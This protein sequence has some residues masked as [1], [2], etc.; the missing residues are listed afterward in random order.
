[1]TIGDCLIYSNSFY[2]NLADFIFLKYKVIFIQNIKD[3]VLF[4]SFFLT[5]SSYQLINIIFFFIQFLI[6]FHGF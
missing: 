3:N 5:Y 1:M 6:Q 2:G 4:D